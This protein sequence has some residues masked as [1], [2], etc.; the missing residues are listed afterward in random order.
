MIFRILLRHTRQHSAKHQHVTDTGLSSANT[1][2][3][4]QNWNAETTG[5]STN[6]KICF[7]KSSR[8]F[9]NILP[10]EGGLEKC[11]TC[12]WSPL[13]SVRNTQPPRA[14]MQTFHSAPSLFKYFL[15]QRGTNEIQQQPFKKSFSLDMESTM[16]TIGKK[17][18]NNTISCKQVD[19]IIRLLRHDK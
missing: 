4:H 19:S 9:Q 2:G 8:Q 1:Q 7:I 17:R 6:Q 5:L 11:K 18:K 3:A 14:Q 16:L 13:E 10:F 12:F 15:L